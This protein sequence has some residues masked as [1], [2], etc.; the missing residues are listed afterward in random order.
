MLS[1][2]WPDFIVLHYQFNVVGVVG[3]V[4]LAK[5]LLLSNCIYKVVELK[6]LVEVVVG[7]HHVCPPDCVCVVR[8]SAVSHPGVVALLSE[9]WVLRRSNDVLVVVDGAYVVERLH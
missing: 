3:L 9:F 5:T 6:K 2:V 8:E 4:P 1:N 7:V